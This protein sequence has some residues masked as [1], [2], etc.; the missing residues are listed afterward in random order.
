MLHGESVTT[1]AGNGVVL[2][3]H[4]VSNPIRPGNHG[5]DRNGG[6]HPTRSRVSV[7]KRPLA[8]P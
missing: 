6:L 2:G 4:D 8:G 5:F 1:S 7:L 3:R